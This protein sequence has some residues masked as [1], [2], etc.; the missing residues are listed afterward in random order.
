M[1]QRN[2]QKCRQTGMKTEQ[3]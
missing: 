3:P 2:G 1:G